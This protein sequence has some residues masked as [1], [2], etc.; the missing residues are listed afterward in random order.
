M[1]L[2]IFPRVFSEIFGNTF[3]AQ[4]IQT[5]D[6]VSWTLGIMFEIN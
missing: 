6:S 2:Q 3:F 4:Y 1:K 5:A